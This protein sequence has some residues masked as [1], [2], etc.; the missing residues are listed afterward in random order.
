[1]EQM[2]QAFWLCVVMFA[3]LIIWRILDEMDF[4]N[5]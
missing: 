5:E 4:D 2:E 1:M 3:I